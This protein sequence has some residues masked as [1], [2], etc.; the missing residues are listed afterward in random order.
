[1]VFGAM[2]VQDQARAVAV[3]MGERRYGMFVRADNSAYGRFSA[4]S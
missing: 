1:M 2:N 3:R 4:Q